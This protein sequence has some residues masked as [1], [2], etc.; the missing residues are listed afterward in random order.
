MVNLR[1]IGTC[2]FL[3]YV[4]AALSIPGM[5]VQMC[6]NLSLLICILCFIWPADGRLKHFLRWLK[7]P[8]KLLKTPKL[9]SLMSKKDRLQPLWPSNK[10]NS[11]HCQ[12][13]AHIYPYKCGEYSYIKLLCCSSFT[14][15]KTPLSQKRQF[16]SFRTK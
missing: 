9:K 4:N 14:V 3:G 12:C 7:K 16:E 11:V 5:Q 15:Q 6:T 13:T 2:D 8:W 10:A 1:H